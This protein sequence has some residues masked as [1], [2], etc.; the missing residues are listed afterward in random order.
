M[1]VTYGY[2]SG[3]IDTH[4]FQ[5]GLYLPDSVDLGI[6]VTYSLNNIDPTGI[7]TSGLTGSTT[8][9]TW[10]DGSHIAGFYTNVIN[11]SSTP[12]P[13]Y[14]AHFVL[15]TLNCYVDLNYPAYGG[16]D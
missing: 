3:G 4:N 10:T 13:T 16:S 2:I 15:P 8:V 7:I 9:T 6:P 12:G 11:L 14:V 5:L 1:T